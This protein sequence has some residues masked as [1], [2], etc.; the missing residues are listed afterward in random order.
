M[1]LTHAALAA[2]AIVLCASDALA[3][4][5]RPAQ[6]LPDDMNMARQ[7]AL[8]RVMTVAPANN[9]RR[10]DPEILRQTGLGRGSCTV[11]VAPLPEN[12]PKTG[13]LG[14]VNQVVVVEAAPIIACGM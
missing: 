14:T 1:Q 13:G 11:N 3:Q 2:L 10:G 7:Q 8:A 4:P 12:H 6:L 9:Q 5:Q